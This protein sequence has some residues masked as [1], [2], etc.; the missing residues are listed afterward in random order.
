MADLIKP[1]LNVKVPH[2][3]DGAGSWN[4]DVEELNPWAWDEQVFTADECDSIIHL[5]ERKGLRQGRVVGRGDHEDSRQSDI[6]FIF[7]DDT[8]S[9]IFQ[10]TTKVIVDL[11]RDFF[12]FDVTGFGE[13]MQFTRYTA[14]GEK[15]DWHVDATYRQARRKLSFSILL[16]DPNE[17]EGGDFQVMLGGD[18]TTLP[19]KRGTML[20]F[21]SYTVHRVTPVTKGTR[22][23]LVAWITGP[24]FR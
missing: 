3:E 24:P 14:P 10:R 23:S 16:S 15:Y 4:F 13:G 20:A 5:A 22:Y 9:W 17:Y 21:P 1:N 8:T 11:N 12:G 2:L 7:P 6:R 18:P 19:R